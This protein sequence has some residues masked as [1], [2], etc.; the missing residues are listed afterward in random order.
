LIHEKSQENGKEE[1]YPTG[2]EIEAGPENSPG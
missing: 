1:A 2:K